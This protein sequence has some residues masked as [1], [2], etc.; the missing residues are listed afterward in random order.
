M[1]KVLEKLRTNSRVVNRAGWS[2]IWKSFISVPLMLAIMLPAAGRW[3]YLG[4]WLYT[5]SM[6]L[7]L[8]FYFLILLYYNPELINER[9]RPFRKDTRTFDFKFFVVWRISLVIQLLLAAMDKR[10]GWSSLPVVYVWTSFIVISLFNFLEMWPIVINRHFEATVRLQTD[11]NHRVV[12]SGPYRWIRHPGYAFYIPTLFFTPIML[13][14][15]WSMIPSLVIVGAFVVRTN[16]EDR[17]LRKELTGYSDYASR[18]RWKL[19]PW[20]W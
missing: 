13:E 8:P 19:F 1:G 6:I 10:Y 4:A 5:M 12:D 18:V 17:M 7:Y 14:S 11:R 20:I 2:T 3:D 9:G 15:L 16:L